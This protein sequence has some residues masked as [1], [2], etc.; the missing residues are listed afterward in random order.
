MASATANSGTRRNASVT[1]ADKQV[2][3]ISRAL[4]DPRRMEILRLLS[5]G[6][7]QCAEL[8]QCLP[9]NAPTMSHHIKELETAGL[10]QTS[11]EGKFLHMSLRRDTWRAYLTSLKGLAP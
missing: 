4:A 7:K 11:R 9:I 3:A 1:L 8:R 2:L 6:D 5:S 10:I